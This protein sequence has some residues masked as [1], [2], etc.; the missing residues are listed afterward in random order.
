[1]TLLKYKDK[2]HSQTIGITFLQFIKYYYFNVIF[3]TNGMY[4]YLPCSPRFPTSQLFSLLMGC[5]SIY[6]FLSDLQHTSS[7]PAGCNGFSRVENPR[8]I[9]RK[10]ESIL[11]LETKNL[12]ISNE[13]GKPI[14]QQVTLDT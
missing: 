12:P 14:L 4:L 2:L 9:F 8:K 3:I 1:M 6:H 7:K 5:T 11:P 13:R 10:V